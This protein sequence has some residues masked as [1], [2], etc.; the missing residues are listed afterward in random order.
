MR[1]ELQEFGLCPCAFFIRRLEYSLLDRL[2]VVCVNFE[3]GLCGVHSSGLL[4]ILGLE[5]VTLWVLVA[6]QV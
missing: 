6:S 4:S 2:G 1:F 5:E 3:G